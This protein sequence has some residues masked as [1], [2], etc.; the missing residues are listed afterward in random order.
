MNFKQMLVQSFLCFFFFFFFFF[1][2]LWSLEFH[3][4]YIAKIVRV[5]DIELALTE[6]EKMRSM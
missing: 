6:T 2:P 5:Q 1:L 4:T 3:C